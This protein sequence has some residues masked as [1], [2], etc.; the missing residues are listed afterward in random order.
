MHA[1]EATRMTP[2]MPTTSTLSVHSTES[3]APQLTLN[4]NGADRNI[5]SNADTPF[6]S[7]SSI[8]KSPHVLNSDSN[9]ISVSG[10]NL[11]HS[12]SNSNTRFPG[13]DRSYAVEMPHD[14]TSPSTVGRNQREDARGASEQGSDAHA[15]RKYPVAI[16]A[17]SIATFSFHSPFVPTVLFLATGVQLIR[18]SLR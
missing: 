17:V 18:A 5:D 11:N 16:G 3:S 2:S 4:S 8:H 7:A 15:S 1:G 9:S 6:Q 13:T 14:V 10:A 12:N